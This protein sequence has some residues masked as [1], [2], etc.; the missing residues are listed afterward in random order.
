MRG[1]PFEAR[2]KNPSV[3]NFVGSAQLKKLQNYRSTF[4]ADCQG[5]P[6]KIDAIEQHI[7]LLSK[8]FS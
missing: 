1:S 2:K 7:F 6:E 4:L 8:V 3:S 5:N